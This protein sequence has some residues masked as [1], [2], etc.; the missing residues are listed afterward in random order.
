VHRPVVVLLII[1]VGLTAPVVAAVFAF[2]R[3]SLVLTL[4][5]LGAA[6]LWF[7]PPL[8][9]VTTDASP[10]HDQP[11]V[12]KRTF[13]HWWEA[14]PSAPPDNPY[15]STSYEIYWPQ[16]CT[17]AAALVVVVTGLYFLLRF[18]LARERATVGAS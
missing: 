4:L 3:P 10:D 12:T 13:G 9:E 17:E 7:S 11:V 8:L 1:A 2:R 14:A 6:F 5:I 18:A 15:R 16:L